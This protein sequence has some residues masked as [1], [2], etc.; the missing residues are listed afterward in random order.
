MRFLV[1]MQVLV[2]RLSGLCDCH[3]IRLLA[4]FGFWAAGIADIKFSKLSF[5]RAHSS[6]QLGVLGS[7]FSS[8]GRKY[9]SIS[10]CGVNCSVF[11]A[12]LGS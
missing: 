7:R 6:P 2:V 11:K 8:P 9:F 3:I 5:H 12:G 10:S 1:L 4:P